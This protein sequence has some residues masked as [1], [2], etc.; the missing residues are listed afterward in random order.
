MANEARVDHLLEDVD[1]VIDCLNALD[2]VPRPM[3]RL[4]GDEAQLRQFRQ[5]RRRFRDEKRKSAIGRLHRRQNVDERRMHVKDVV[6]DDLVG[7][8]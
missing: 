8:C 6:V 2:L 5:I 4:V 3:N 7:G 1:G